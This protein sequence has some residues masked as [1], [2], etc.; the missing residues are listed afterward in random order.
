MHS[1]HVLCNIEQSQ[2]GSTYNRLGNFWRP[3]HHIVACGARFNSSS[4][5]QQWHSAYSCFHCFSIGTSCWSKNSTY[6]VQAGELGNTRSSE[7]N[8]QL[9]QGVCCV[10]CWWWKVR[11]TWIHLCTQL[12]TAHFISAHITDVPTN[13]Y[14]LVLSRCQILLPVVLYWV[15]TM[16]I[17]G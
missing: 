17:Y 13:S 15:I 3:S 5:W 10:S 7:W 14:S 4:L 16:Y 6:Y 8:H 2:C 11:Q 12:I 1:C 9:W